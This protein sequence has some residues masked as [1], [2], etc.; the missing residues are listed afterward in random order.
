M[1]ILSLLLPQLDGAGPRVSAWPTQLPLNST[2]PVPGHPSSAHSLPAAPWPGLS[3]PGKLD[4]SQRQRKL[5][6]VH[7]ERAQYLWANLIV[8]P[9]CELL[10]NLPFNPPLLESDAIFTG[11]STEEVLLGEG[12]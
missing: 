7:K 8:M 5:I 9:S 6:P 10:Y 12:K 2:L 3:L 11:E 1:V 4:F